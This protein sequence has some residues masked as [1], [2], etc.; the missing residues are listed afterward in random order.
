MF[1]IDL[2]EIFFYSFCDQV[3]LLEKPLQSLESLE[4]EESPNLSSKPLMN[5]HSSVAIAIHSD[6]N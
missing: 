5:C 2:Q 4:K 1:R 3:F 6:N